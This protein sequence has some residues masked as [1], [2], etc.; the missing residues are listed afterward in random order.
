MLL[1]WGEGHSSAVHDHADAHCFMK[2]LDGA[3]NEVRFAWPDGDGA[4]HQ[5]STGVEP[6]ELQV[7]GT[8]KL[9]T[10]GVCY[11]NGI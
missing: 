4:E 6:H 8:S 9:E 5:T 11:I 1:C 2:I 10:N 7:L 3:L